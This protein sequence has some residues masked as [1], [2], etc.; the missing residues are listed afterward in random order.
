MLSPLNTGITFAIF[1]SR[2]S[3]PDVKDCLKIM[4]KICLEIVTVFF[5]IFELILSIPEDGDNF[6]L[7]IKDVMPSAVISIGSIKGYSKSGIKGTVEQSFCVKTDVKKLL[8]ATGQSASD[9]G[10]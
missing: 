1:Q 10:L 7:F 9:K 4:H 5:S 8:N 3:S 2:G 6:R